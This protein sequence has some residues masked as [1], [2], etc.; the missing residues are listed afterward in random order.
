VLGSTPLEEHYTLDDGT[1]RRIVGFQRAT[2]DRDFQHIDYASGDG[3]TLRFG[4]GE[5]GRTPADELKF[6]VIYRTGPGAGSNVSAGAIRHVVHPLTRAT[7][8]DEDLQLA[9]IVSVENPLPVTDGVDPEDLEQI[10]QLAP[11]EFRAI[12]HR[13]VTPADYCDIVG[14]LPWVQ[15]PGVRLRWTGSWPSYFVTPDPIGSYKVTSEQRSELTGLLDCIRQ[16]GREVHTLDPRFRAI[17]L[18]IK[19]CVKPGHIP[20]EVRDRVLRRLTG[21]GVRPGYFNFDTFTFGQPLHRFTLEGIVGAVPGVLGV[22]EIFI[23]ARAVHERRELE[24]LYVVPDNE[25]LRLANDPRTP[26]RGSV[27]VYTEGGV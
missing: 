24:P 10:K 21:D 11:E 12:T 14:R 9:K 22:R 15:T 18:E 17:D 3:F 7:D 8:L 2:I 4:D 26:E 5:F 1:L 20:S 16:A 13:A 27:R 6:R 19:I 25:I 23:S